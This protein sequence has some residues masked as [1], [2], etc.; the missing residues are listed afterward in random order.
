[1][2][3]N[4]RRP[5]TSDLGLLVLRV[6]TSGMMMTHGL[7]KLERWD[8]L[9]AVFA[10]PIGLGPAISLGLAVFAELFCSIA[11]AAG[12]L[13]RLAAIPPLVTMLV[14]AFIVHADDPWARKEL[15]LLYATVFASIVLLGA[16]RHSVDGALRATRAKR[17]RA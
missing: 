1:M 14:A 11:I 2:T 7:G 5:F 12:A 8:S 15:A 10:D 13:T 17:V 6:A 3:S 16:G 9:V 4:D